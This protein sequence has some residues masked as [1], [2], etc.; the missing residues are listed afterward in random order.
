MKQQKKSKRFKIIVGFAVIAIIGIAVYWRQIDAD[1]ARQ[2]VPVQ[3]IMLERTD[4]VRSLSASGVVQSANVQNVFSTMSSPIREIFVS[5][6][7]RVEI[8]DVLAV[9]DMSR[10]E[11]DIR[12]ANLNLMSAE[13]SYSEERRSNINSVTSARTSLEASLISL[14]RQELATY[15]AERDLMEAMD[16]LHRPFDSRAHIRMIEDAE[17][18]LARRLADYAEAQTNLEDAE[19]VVSNFDDFTLV[20]IIN[21]ARIILDRRY[22]ALTEAREDLEEVLNRQNE[23]FDDSA[24]R[25]AVADAERNLLRRQQD[26]ETAE[27]NQSFIESSQGAGGQNFIEMQNADTA[28]TNAER[29]VEDAT[30]AL[31]RAN[32]NLQSAR[33]NH[34]SFQSDIRD[35][36]IAAAERVLENAEIAYEDARRTYVRALL[37]LD[38]AR[39]N[40]EEATEAAAETARE[41]ANNH[42]NRV[43]DSLED[44]KRVLERALADYERA[45]HDFIEANDE[46][47]DTRLRNT[48][49]M[50]EDSR[51]QLEAAHNN[52]R[53]AQNSL[54]QVSHRSGTS[55]INVE[56]QQLNLERLNEQ[57]NDG[58][59]TATASGVIAEVNASVG[60]PPSGILFVIVDVENLYVSAN[61]REHTLHEIH[62]G[63]TG[64]VTTVATGDRIYDAE[65]N[66][67]SPRAVSPPGSTSVEFE[68]RARVHAS[69]MDIRIGMNAFLNVIIESKENVYV[70]PLTAISTNEDG[71]FVNAVYNGHTWEIP[72]STGLRTSTH[73]E[74]HGEGL[75]EG[76]EIVA[77]PF[78]M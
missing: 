9:L 74:I 47:N 29:A 15:N 31:Y 65:V 70:V 78:G 66:F 23:S 48:T 55:G 5:V 32:S 4:I 62:L 10:L 18:N 56:M 37:D 76:L 12:Q 45:I 7:D 67:I 46:A 14:K 28:V 59:I 19:D 77:R 41:A 33:N 42:L 63:Q 8:G 49:R 69:D 26:L 30:I 68:I 6:G 57:L 54:N 73:T 50:Y 34:D 60:A 22:A 38:R 72:V 21:D 2:A 52:V 44:A 16:V 71:S 61:V 75:F 39:Q 27:E 35:N 51:I 53:S 40:A 64:K 24:L 36:A 25:H 58:V 1:A 13:L 20:N 11:S 43:R 17:Q 3:T